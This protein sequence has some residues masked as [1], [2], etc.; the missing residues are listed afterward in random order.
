MVC[1][2]CNDQDKDNCM[3]CGIFDDQLTASQRKV[4]PTC[5]CGSTAKANTVMTCTGTCGRSFHAACV[6][7]AGLTRSTFR[8][9]TSWKCPS[10][11]KWSPDLLEKLGEED[12]TEPGSVKEEVRNEVKS[13]MP[14]IV[15]EVVA[16]VKSALG[17]TS[18]E[19]LVKE[20]NDKIAKGWADIAKSEQKLII[21]E[22]VGQTSDSAVTKSLSRISADLTEQR[23]RSRN[24]VI[25][26]VPEGTGGN[27]KSLS[28]VVSDITGGYLDPNDIAHCN[29]LGKK[30][31]TGSGRLILVVVKREDWAAEF[32]NFGRGRKLDGNIWVNPD[33]TTTEREAQYRARNLRR[34]KRNRPPVRDAVADEPVADEQPRQAN[35]ESAPPRNVRQTGR[36]GVRSNTD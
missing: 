4:N 5:E 11:F 16:G 15:N 1:N 29:R 14:T 24:C 13:I 9:I 20:A 8:V 25:S 7:L 22:V 31:D 33:L 28:E 36:S 2:S 32:H 17:P 18:V 30:K 21:Q 6:G 35:E 34:E 10:C 23:T 26:N 19:K 12:K 3:E 27:E